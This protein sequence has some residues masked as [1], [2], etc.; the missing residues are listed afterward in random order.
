M[1]LIGQKIA[2]VDM[3][4]SGFL[5][6][7]VSVVGA[8]GARVPLWRFPFFP[9]LALLVDSV[10]D[11][12]HSDRLSG[13]SVGVHSRV[14]SSTAT[15]SRLSQRVLLSKPGCQGSTKTFHARK[16]AT[17]NAARVSIVIKRTS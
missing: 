7:F 3:L 13:G 5:S 2:V 14:S 16:R 10:Q 8:H 4:L 12:L 15:L 17:V 1:A 6:M 11:S 9:L